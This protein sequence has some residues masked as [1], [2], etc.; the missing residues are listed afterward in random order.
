MALQLPFQINKIE[1]QHWKAPLS[2]TVFNYKAKD[3][4]PTNYVDAYQVQKRL[5]TDKADTEYAI[6]VKQNIYS[7][8]SL[9]L[10]ILNTQIS[11]K[12]SRESS[13]I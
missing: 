13:V 5:L 6:Q 3:K 7:K 10:T 2:K 12:R 1:K 11:Y 8:K 4:F 9:T